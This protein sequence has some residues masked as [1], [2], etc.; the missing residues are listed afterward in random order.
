MSYITNIINLYASGII[1][2]FTFYDHTYGF[3][4]SLILPDSLDIMSVLVGKMPFLS[5]GLNCFTVF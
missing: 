1:Y 2:A 3:V 5:L 4:F